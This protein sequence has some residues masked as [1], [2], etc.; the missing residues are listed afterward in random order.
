LKYFLGNSPQNA[1]FFAGILLIIAAFLTLCIKEVK[2]ET[3]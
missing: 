3:T 2:A 1:I